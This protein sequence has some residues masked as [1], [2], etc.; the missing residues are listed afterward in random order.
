MDARENL[1]FWARAVL[2]WLAILVLAILNG[3]LREA[4]LVPAL[5]R[6]GALAASGLALAAL[7]L[8]A[9]LLSARWL[10]AGAQRAWRLGLAWLGLTLAFEFGFGA[11]LQGKPLAQLLAAYALSDGNLWPL[12]L[13][14]I[15]VAPVL[16]QRVRGRRA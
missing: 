9:A 4:W 1:R 5:G 15:V 7:V 12:V 14:V 2:A 16:A 10:D 6:R 3:V 8:L 11:L 13:A